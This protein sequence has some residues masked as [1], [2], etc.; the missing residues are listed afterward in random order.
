VGTF[1]VSSDISD[2]M[3]AQSDLRK[4]AATY[5]RKNRE[6]AEELELAREVQQ[7]L[8]PDKFPTVFGGGA[9]MNFFRLYEPARLL[10]GEFFEVLPL[11]SGSGWFFN[12]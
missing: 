5:E 2:L 7:A 8:L 11:A 10:T 12:G 4:L 6:M 1:G 3:Q 9:A